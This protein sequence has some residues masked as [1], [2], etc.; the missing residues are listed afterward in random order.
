VREER[1]SSGWD[2]S[3]RFRFRM[4]SEFRVAV[5]AIDVRS[6]SSSSI[7]VDVVVLS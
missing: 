1:L 6:R 5:A 2:K 4:P 7:V 3:S